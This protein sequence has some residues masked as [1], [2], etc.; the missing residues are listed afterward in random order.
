L[1]FLNF[2]SRKEKGVKM[3][4]LISMLVFLGSLT[5]VAMGLIGCSAKAGGDLSGLAPVPAVEP[6]KVEPTL[7]CHEDQTVNGKIEGKNWNF[8]TGVAFDSAFQ[9]VWDVTLYDEKMNDPCRQIGSAR[10]IK[11]YVPKAVGEFNLLD[12][13]AAYFYDMSANPQ[14]SRMT[15]NGRGVVEV[16]DQD[17]MEGSIE[18]YVD[19]ETGVCGKWKVF[20]CQ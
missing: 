18:A 15:S 5:V 14:V 9:G 19:A 8:K 6:Q 4:N 11:L 7:A 13:R 12:S 17:F 10:G 20:I 16:L 1:V 3:K 2:I